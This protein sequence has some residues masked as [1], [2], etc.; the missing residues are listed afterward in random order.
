MPTHS[1]VYAAPVVLEPF[2][3]L[4]Q[5]RGHDRNY[6][7]SLSGSD[8]QVQIT[9]MSGLQRSASIHAGAG[10]FQTGWLT[11]ATNVWMMEEAF[12]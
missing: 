2:S 12:L 7:A 6:I 10:R 5:G 4:E 3:H 1:V 11:I 8:V 9:P